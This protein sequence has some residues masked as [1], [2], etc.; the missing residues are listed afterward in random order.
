MEVRLQL[1]QHVFLCDRVIV[2][3]DLPLRGSGGAEVVVDRVDVQRVE[4]SAAVAVRVARLI[5]DEF[6]DAVPARVPSLAERVYVPGALMIRLLNVATPF[7][8]D[9]ETELPLEAN[10][11]LLSVSVTVELSAAIVFPEVSCTATTT[12]GLMALP[13]RVVI[14]CWVKLSF[15]APTEILKVWDVLP[16]KC[17]IGWR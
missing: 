8:A 5:D 17:P 16:V 2:R 1:V 12:S 9:A 3:C 6:V 7:T 11:P 4:Q 15:H 14:G 13:I 10:D